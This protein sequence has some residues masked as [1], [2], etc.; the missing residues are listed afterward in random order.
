MA[1]LRILFSKAPKDG[2]LSTSLDRLPAV[3]GAGAAQATNL[4]CARAV[5][6]VNYRQAARIAAVVR[7]VQFME[8]G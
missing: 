8:P 6:H 3:R 4:L 5:F 7:T 2:F 1:G